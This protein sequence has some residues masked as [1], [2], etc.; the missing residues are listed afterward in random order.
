MC[1][2]EENAMLESAHTCFVSYRGALPAV[3]ISVDDDCEGS[4][5]D[6]PVTPPDVRMRSWSVHDDSSVRLR[7][8]LCMRRAARLRQPNFTSSRT[9]PRTSNSRRREPCVAALG[10]RSLEGEVEHEASTWI[11]VAYARRSRSK[12]LGAIVLFR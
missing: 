11:G 12:I 9:T 3:K 4:L 6:C 8:L 2:V 10:S 7:G 1:P 5:R